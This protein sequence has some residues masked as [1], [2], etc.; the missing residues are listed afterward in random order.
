M[1]P[2]ICNRG[3]MIPTREFMTRLSTSCRANNALLIID[4][5][6]TGFMRTG[7]MFGCEHF[8]LK[9]DILCLGK[10]ITGGFAPMGAT[11]MTEKV[12]GAM[13]YESSYY[14]TY[15]WH[16]LS[17]EAALATL[18]YIEKNKGYLEENTTE[19]SHFIIDRIQSMD[20]RETP[21][22]SSKGLAIGVSFESEN[23]GSHIVEKAEEEGL[24]ISEGENGFT[25]FP[26]L[27][28]DQRTAN[29]GLDILEKCARK[30]IRETQQ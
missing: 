25:L 26:A 10:A 14:S 3:V 13:H 30:P 21:K 5:V 28:I 1:E 27:T 8:D 11:L 4:E 18:H 22:V 24:I 9:P 15:G 20:F 19:M 17:V 7:K 16:P 29:E 2:F 12:A 23:Y 6:A